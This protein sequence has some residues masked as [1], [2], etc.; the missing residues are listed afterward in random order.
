MEQTVEAT[1]NRKRLISSALLS[2][3]IAM[4]SVGLSGMCWPGGLIPVP[5]A[6]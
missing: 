6:C 3:G 1:R 4:V 2:A 5:I